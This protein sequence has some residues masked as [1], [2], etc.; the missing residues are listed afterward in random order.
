MNKHI[1]KLLKA[2]DID[3][4]EEEDKGDYKIEIG[5][6]DAFGRTVYSVVK[7]SDE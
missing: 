3:D 4:K 7:Q 1:Q 5:G 6:K 2:S